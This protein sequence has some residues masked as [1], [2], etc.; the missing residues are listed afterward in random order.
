MGVPKS[1][2]VFVRTVEILTAE[3]NSSVTSNALFP[4]QPIPALVATVL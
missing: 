1:S 2:S 3:P 4:I